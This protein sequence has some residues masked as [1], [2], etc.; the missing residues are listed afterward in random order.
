MKIYMSVD[1]EGVAGIV[2]WDYTSIT[3][4]QYDRARRLMTGEVNAAVKGALRAGAQEIVVNDSHNSMTN[5]LFEDLLPPASLL[6]GSPKVNSMMEGLDASFAGVVLI[7][8]HSMMNTRGVLNHSYSSASVYCLKI[9]GAETG[10]LG[11][12]AY[13][14]GHYNVPVLMITGDDELVDEAKKLIPGAKAVQVKEARGR[15]AALNR[16]Y[17][18]VRSLIEDAAAEAV[19][20]RDKIEPVK[21]Q[22]PVVIE[23]TLANSGMA[24]AAQIMPGIERTGP[25]ILTY[26][27]NDIL[28]AYRAFRTITGLAAQVK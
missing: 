17:C 8:Y 9:N 13:I 18:E 10:E 5:I 14:A 27:A 3:G 20:A 4:T 12:N 16:N 23:V 19:V 1:M 26:E 15:Y 6:S 21:I 25:N 11:I 22:G 28:T 7:G 24:D 2:N